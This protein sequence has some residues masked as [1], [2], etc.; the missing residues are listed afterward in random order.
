M[1]ENLE[2]TK[3]EETLY[4]YAKAGKIPIYGGFELTPYCNFSCKM[5]FV[6]ETAPDLPLIRA[7]QWLDFGCQ[8]VA[9]GTLYIVL[10]GGEPLSHPDFKQIYTGLKQMGIVLTINTN[11]SLIDENMADF[12]AADMPRRVNVSLYGPNAEVYEQLCGNRAGFARTIHAIE[13]M[14][15]RRIP[16]KINIVPNTINYPYLDEMLAIC[17][18]YELPVEMTSYLFEPI[19][20]TNPGHQL[21]RLEPDQMAMARIKWD[22]YRYGEQEMIG[23][24][25]L[26]HQGLEHFE[27][28]RQTE[29][30]VP[31]SCQAG[32]SSFWLCWDGKM[33]ACVNMIRP[34][35]DVTQL[36][37]EVA[38]ELVKKEG[39]NIRVAAQ[40]STCSLQRFCLTCASIP[41]HQYGVFDR[42]P[43]IMCAATEHYARIMAENVKKASE[44]Q[45]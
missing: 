37:F 36:G 27:I 30:K 12:L 9:A 29:G 19:R 32:N 22:W 21:Y 17:K 35:A 3:V 8:A 34:Q 28:S 39:A 10:T 38:W 33:N 40:C 24:A 2:R 15:A 25:I 20:K 4:A 45:H 5:C 13:L 42:V 41:F 23:R 16:V 7:D 11:A 6:H 44:E 1:K 18:R 43:D 31:L 14:L 26:C